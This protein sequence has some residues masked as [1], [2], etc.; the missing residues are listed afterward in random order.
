M[1]GAGNPNA[2][3]MHLT[4]VSIVY[5]VVAAKK[6]QVTF[7]VLSSL[8]VLAALCGGISKAAECHGKVS[9]AK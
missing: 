9:V 2:I 7:R 8:L 5:A 3:C 4:A 6:M 1:G